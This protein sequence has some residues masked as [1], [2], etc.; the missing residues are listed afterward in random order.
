MSLRSRSFGHLRAAL[1]ELPRHSSKMAGA[2]PQKIGYS[3]GFFDTN[4]RRAFAS[5]HDSYLKKS[6]KAF[7]LDSYSAR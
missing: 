7:R 1:Y 5:T 6:L 2:K 3:V 4:I